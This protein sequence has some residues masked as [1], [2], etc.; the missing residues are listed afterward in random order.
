MLA[1]LHDI[2]KEFRRAGSKDDF[3]RPIRRHEEIENRLNIFVAVVFQLKFLNYLKNIKFTGCE[4]VIDYEKLL[5]HWANTE[6]NTAMASSSKQ[7]RKP[8]R[9]WL[10][11]QLRGC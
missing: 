5:I 10:R 8:L 3:H 7:H 11:L 6:Q 9:Q 4:S 2:F 1:I